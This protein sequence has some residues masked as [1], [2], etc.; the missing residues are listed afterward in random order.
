LVS[1]ST[2]F[3]CGQLASVTQCNDKKYQAQYQKLGSFEGENMKRQRHS[4]D[5][6]QWKQHYAEL[7]LGVPGDK[8]GI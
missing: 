2:T 4:G 5:F 8:C 6:T 3:Q 1:S 7:E